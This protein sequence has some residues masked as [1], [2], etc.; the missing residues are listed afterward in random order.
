MKDGWKML[1]IQ[2][3]ICHMENV[4]KLLKVWFRCYYVFLELVVTITLI[5][6][7]LEDYAE[8][9]EN[10]KINK[11]D[12]QKPRINF[13]RKINDQNVDRFKILNEYETAK[14]KLNCNCF[15]ENK[16]NHQLNIN[17]NNSNTIDNKEIQQKNL[18]SSMLDSEILKFYS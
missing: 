10:I 9:K 6:T 4:I 2:P 12:A 16:N 5:I 15:K 1:L 18:N 3:R 7:I 13:Y 8:L 17:I 14:F 11:I